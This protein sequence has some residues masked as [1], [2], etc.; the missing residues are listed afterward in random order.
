MTDKQTQLVDSIAAGV[1][2]RLSLEFKALAE[3][4]AKQTV[5]LNASLARLATLEDAVNSS[6]AAKRAVRTAGAAKKAAA[7]G[8]TKKGGDDKSRVT[9]ALLYF[10]YAMSQDLD[11]AREE[12]GT[13]ENLIE[14]EKDSTVSKRDRVKDDVGFWSA[15]G[16][17]LWKTVLSDEQKETIRGQ[18]TA[19]KEEAARNDAEP[20]LEP[21]E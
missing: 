4:L 3:Q 14:A 7:G 18:Y 19:W 15:V 16:A 13:E 17:A 10:R 9:N 21:E 1:H 2:A 5:T 12:Y 8:K 6:T 20:Q 11:D